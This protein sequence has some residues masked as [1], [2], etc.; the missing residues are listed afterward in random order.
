M[1][2]CSPILFP[3]PASWNT[4]VTI[5]WWVEA[6]WADERKIT[7]ESGATGWKEFSLWMSHLPTNSS[8]HFFNKELILEF[9][10]YINIVLILTSP[11]LVQFVSV[12]K[13]VIIKS[14]I[15]KKSYTFNVHILMHFNKCIHCNITTVKVLNICITS[16]N[17]LMSFCLYMCVFCL[18]FIFGF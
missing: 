13:T 4:D 18:G 6:P 10:Y 2:M 7:E 16:T 12:L 3:L 14:I 5:I 15:Y 9:I 8:Q 11:T 1:A 17:F